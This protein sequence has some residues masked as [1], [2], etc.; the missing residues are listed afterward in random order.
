MQ[1]RCQDI[2]HTEIQL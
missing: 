1:L 2:I